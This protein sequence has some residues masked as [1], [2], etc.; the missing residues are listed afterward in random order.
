HP[1]ENEAKQ[2]A[3]TKRWHRVKAL[4]FG[5][6]CGAVPPSC[7]LACARCSGS[8]QTLGPLGLF[9]HTF[10]SIRSS[11]PYR[12]TGTT[13]SRPEMGR[14]WIRVTSVTAFLQSLVASSASRLA[15]PCNLCR[16]TA[17]W[18]LNLAWRYIRK[19]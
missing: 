15:S 16:C 10:E 4:G 19:N 6:D 14:A 8:G 13:N 18:L 12:P 5:A 3:C 11:Q 7:H 2:G 9:K 17:A 1:E